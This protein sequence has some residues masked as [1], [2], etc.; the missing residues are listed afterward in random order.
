VFWARVENLQVEVIIQ[1][2][3]WVDV[4]AKQQKLNFHASKEHD[5]EL[6]QKTQTHEKLRST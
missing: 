2:E 1:I 4:R 6:R 3:F 5:K